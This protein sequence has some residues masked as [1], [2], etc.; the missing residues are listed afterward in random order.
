MRSF[1]VSASCSLRIWSC[2]VA[3][4]ACQHFASACIRSASTRSKQA[5]L[6]C[7]A[8]WRLPSPHMPSKPIE[9]QQPKSNT[10]L[11]NVEP[12]FCLPSGRGDLPW[13]ILSG[14][15]SDRACMCSTPEVNCLLVKSG[16]WLW[17]FDV[18][19]IRSPRRRSRNQPKQYQCK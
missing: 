1:R 14:T 16:S 18:E 13:N 3:S 7:V 2:F 17:H 11:S 12:L 4:S 9:L 19:T 8:R 5:P 10:P 6:P 15:E